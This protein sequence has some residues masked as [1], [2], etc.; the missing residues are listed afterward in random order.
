MMRPRIDLHVYSLRFAL[1]FLWQ[2]KE[3]G[4]DLTERSKGE[5]R[6]ETK[7]LKNGLAIKPGPGPA[8]SEFNR[9]RLYARQGPCR[10]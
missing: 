2:G 9:S 1:R 6:H 4:V 8:Y 10:Q 3:R 5:Q 7:D